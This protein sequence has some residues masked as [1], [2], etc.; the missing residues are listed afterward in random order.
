MATENL[1]VMISSNFKQ[2]IFTDQ[3]EKFILEC[4]EEGVF[5]QRKLT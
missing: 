2:V 1:Q 3:K 4:I 5:V